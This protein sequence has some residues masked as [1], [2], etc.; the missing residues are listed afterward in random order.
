MQP[1]FGFTEP[2]AI[3]KWQRGE[4]MPTLENSLIL[5]KLLDVAI[6]QIIVLKAE[7][8]I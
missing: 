7:F 2:Q 6:E 5:G 4:S 3:Y 1:Y 8:K